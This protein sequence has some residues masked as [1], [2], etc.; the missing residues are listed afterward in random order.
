VHVDPDQVAYPGMDSSDGQ[1]GGPPGVQS[2]IERS[3]ARGLSPYVG[4]VWVQQVPAD[5]APY[6]HRT[7]PNACAELVCELGASPRLCWPA[8][9]PD[10]TAHTSWDY[11][12][13]VSA[14]ARCH[15]SPLRRTWPRVRGPYSARGPVLAT[16]ISNARRDC[17]VQAGYADQSHLSRE[18]LRLT[19]RSPRTA[20]GRRH[21]TATGFTI[22]GPP[23]ASRT[24]DTTA[25][26]MVRV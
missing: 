19:G 24:S 18:C 3:P 7:A 6:M 17:R 22:T 16:P 2:F 13:R 8:D 25:H 10:R 15:F 1:P 26:A 14:N 11:H 4:C 23:T 21:I 12:R 5:S 20:L 9:R